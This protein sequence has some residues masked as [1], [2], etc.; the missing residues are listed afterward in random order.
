MKS[1]ISMGKPAAPALVR[2]LSDPRGDVRA[3]AAEAVRAIL[4]V[5]PSNAPNYHDKEFWQE[6]IAQLKT[7]MAL[8][9][10]LKVLLRELSP[11]ERKKR[12][13]GAAWAGTNGNS[14]YRLDDYWVIHLYLIDFG[15][16][17]LQGSCSRLVSVRASSMGCRRPKST[18]AS[19]GRG[20]STGKRP[21]RFS[22][23]TAS[24]TGQSPHSP[25][26]ASNPAS[27][28]TGMASAKALRQ[29]GTEMAR[30][31]TKANTTTASGLGLGVGGM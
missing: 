16:E 3:L 23:A 11:A 29:D 1:L 31:P 17:K 20:T 21:T 26:T 10:A 22:I 19:G 6:R 14:V 2:A 15:M 5:D 28:T 18:R 4:A 7:G 30:R 25:I 27:R 24:M 13:E 8:D 12:C 9:E